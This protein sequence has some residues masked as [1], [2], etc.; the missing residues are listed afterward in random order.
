MMDLDDKI[1][2]KGIIETLR[3]RMVELEDLEATGAATPDTCEMLVDPH[4]LLDKLDTMLLAL[5]DLR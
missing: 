2:S 3:E 5:A 1:V 4:E